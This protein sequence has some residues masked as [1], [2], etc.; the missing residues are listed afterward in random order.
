MIVRRGFLAG[1]LSLPLVASA[2]T[3]ESWEEKRQSQLRDDWPWLGRYAEENRQLLASGKKTNIVFMGDS[4]TEGW[5]RQRQDFFK[6]GRVGRGISGQTTPQMVLRMMADVVAL[7]PRYV[8]IMAATNDVAGNTGKI[9]LAQTCD[10]FRMMTA[11]A[12][13]HRIQVV[14]ASVPPAD[15]FPWRQGLETVKPIRAINVWLKNYAKTA[16]AT[17]IDYWPVLADDKGAMKPGLATDGVHP[18]D[19]GYDLMAT[20][21][22]PFLRARKI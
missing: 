19:Q 22:E 11:I 13:A 1:A 17:W 3:Q 4:I 6:P 20:V 2:Q 18:T 5:R 12:Q 8:H 21:I 7:K 9:T 10:N 15:H 16:G 14:L